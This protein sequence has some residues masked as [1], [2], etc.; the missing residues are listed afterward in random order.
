[1]GAVDEQGRLVVQDDDDLASLWPVGT[2]DMWNILSGD[3]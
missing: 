3:K 1:M 2:S